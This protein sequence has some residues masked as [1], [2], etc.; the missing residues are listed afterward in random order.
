[1]VAIENYNS[2]PP[3]IYTW[4]NQLFLNWSTEINLQQNGILQIVSLNGSI[5]KEY[6]ISN[7][8]TSI[9]LSPLPPGIYI[10]VLQIDGIN[11]R[12]KIYIE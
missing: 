4:N 10:A 1:E 2:I 3:A 5:C 9:N 8:T 12:N 6:N 7:S 11:Y